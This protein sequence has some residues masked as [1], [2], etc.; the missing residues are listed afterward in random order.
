V[1]RLV[2]IL[3]SFLG[4]CIAANSGGAWL[5]HEECQAWGV[6]LAENRYVF[7]FAKMEKA[8]D[9]G[10]DGGDSI[11]SFYDIALDHWRVWPPDGGQT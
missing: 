5:W 1:N 10:L 6:R 7:P 4:E 8:F 9:S 11:L 3:G 2:S